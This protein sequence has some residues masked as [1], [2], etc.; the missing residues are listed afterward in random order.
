[1]TPAAGP[2]QLLLFRSQGRPGLFGVEG[3]WR[4]RPLLALRCLQ[5]DPRLDRLEVALQEGFAARQRVILLVLGR[6]RVH[7]HRRRHELPELGSL[8]RAVFLGDAVA[9]RLK[10]EDNLFARLQA[11]V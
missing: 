11:W 2:S 9:A 5:A 3:T 8:V 4:T 7:A 10:P 6:G 1:M